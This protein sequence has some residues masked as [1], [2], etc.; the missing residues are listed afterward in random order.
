[1]LAFV[2]DFLL[3]FPELAAVASLNFDPHCSIKDWLSL[4]A[5]LS[6]DNFALLLHVIWSIKVYRLI[7]SSSKWESSFCCIRQLANLRV[8]TDQLGFLNLGFLLCRLAQSQSG[9]VG[10]IVHDSQG[11]I[12]GGVCAKLE[13]VGSPELVEFEAR[14]I[15]VFAGV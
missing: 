2:R 1:M 4:C 11:V 9:G 6:K 8:R 13:N 7:N 14:R 5:S 3:V 15:V 12:L 10:L